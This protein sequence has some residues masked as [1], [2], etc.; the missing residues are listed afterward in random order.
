MTRQSTPVL[1][2]HTTAT[3]LNRK[4]PQSQTLGRPLK[5][6][7]TRHHTAKLK[8]MHTWLASLSSNEV[9]CQEIH[10]RVTKTGRQKKSITGQL[11]QELAAR[12]SYTAKHQPIHSQDSKQEPQYHT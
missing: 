8:E 2:T 5:G 4:Q 3:K 1:A 7:K 11:T 12:G 10:I 9:D 6:S